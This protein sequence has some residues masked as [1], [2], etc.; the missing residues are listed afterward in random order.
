M[1]RKM[2]GAVAVGAF[3]LALTGC[4]TAA[5]TSSTGAAK[6]P[7]DIVVGF[8]QV[9]AESGWRT[10]NTKDIQDAFA[11]SGMQLKFS[12]AQQKQENQI[13]AIRSY[14]TQGVDVIAFSPVVE[15]G[16]DAVLKEAKD[17]GIP[18][19]LTDRA[20]D[21]KDDSLYVSF[22]GS[23]FIKEG[24]KAGQWVV[25]EYKNQTDPV[26]IIQLEGTT[27]AAPAIDRAEGFADVIKADPKFQIVASQT[28]DFT[29][30]GGKQVTEA[31]LKSNPDAT[32]IFAHNDDM[33]LGAIE[34]VE[35]AGKVPGKDIK[36][37]TI[38]AVKDGMQALSDGKI[39]FIVECSP[40]L[41]KQLVDIVKK[42][43]AGESVEKRI[44][45]EETTFTQEQAT[46][47]LPTRQY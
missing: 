16:W 15:T 37:V 21:S 2:I 39:N 38:D 41:G 28:G 10:A 17:A 44:L 32:L 36:I 12:D 18:V 26:K 7:G 35:A 31:L 11:A 45:T 13:K 25:D 46:A 47:A 4:S 19:V 30:A 29:R 9:G 22:L 1:I 6:A 3:L 27:G 40:L 43:V 14:I 8:A 23:D 42:V 24:E 34:A 33:G 5:D 20:V